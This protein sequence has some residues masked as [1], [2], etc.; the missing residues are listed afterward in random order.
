MPRLPFRKSASF[1]AT[2]VIPSFRDDEQDGH[3]PARLHDHGS[4]RSWQKLLCWIPSAKRKLQPRGWRVTQAYRAYQ[5]EVNGKKITFLDTPGHE[6]FTAMRARGA[7]VSYRDYRCSRRRWRY[8][9]NT[10]AIDHAQAAKM[11]I[12]IALNK[13][14]KAG[15][16]P[17]RV[18][19]QLYDIGVAVEEFGGDVVCVPVSARR[20]PA[21][22]IARL[23]PLVAE[24]RTSK[25]IPIAWLPV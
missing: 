19:Q 11:P 3:R 12:I 7:Q 10:R 20:G 24:C 22:T 17:D 14:D 15:A 21:S 4:R 16:N 25:L 6:A 18:K 1:S 8:A 5:V 23:Y 2:E 13:I 9:T